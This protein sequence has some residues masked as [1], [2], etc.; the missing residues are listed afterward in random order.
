MYHRLSNSPPDPTPSSDDQATAEIIVGHVSKI[1][2]LLH[3]FDRGT[4]INVSLE[5]VEI[6]NFAMGA[7][8]FFSTTTDKD[9]SYLVGQLQ[10]FKER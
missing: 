1:H 10:E 4:E 3:A 9:K 8:A 2:Q 5:G 7:G 6:S